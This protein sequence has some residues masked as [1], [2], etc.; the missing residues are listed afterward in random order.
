[1]SIFNYTALNEKGAEL[2]GR[3][4][5]DNQRL[6]VT[7][8]RGQSLF[9]VS[10]KQGKT[11]ASLGE[12]QDM[13]SYGS[14]AF[15]KKLLP[16]TAQDRVFFF[17]QLAMM[18][19]SGLTLLSALNHC[20][21]QTG[22]IKLSLAIGRMAKSIQGGNSFSYAIG[23][24]RKIFPIL[25]EKL[26][27]SSEVSGEMEQILEQ[28]ATHLTSRSEQKQNILTSL[29][30]PVIVL[31]VA[32]LVAAFLVIK[33]IPK[34]ALF[35]ARQDMDLPASTQMLIN[36]SNVVRANIPMIIGGGLVM[37]VTFILVYR[38]HKGKLFIDH[39]FLKIPVIG[40]LLTVGAMT[41]MSQTLSILLRSGVTL[42]ESLRVTSGI[43]ENRALHKCLNQA[44]DRILAGKDL[45]SS[46]IHSVVP[47]LVPQVVSV[48]EKSGTLVQVLDELSN[49][50]DKQL[51]A[52][53]KLLAGLIEPFMILIIGGMV[54]FVYLSFFQA[55]L[56]VST[57]R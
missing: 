9:V 6:A 10:I 49:F 25:A 57:G 2:R 53:T 30:Y 16:V 14:F 36:F 4:E 1:M 22:K 31:I 12:L 48:G 40:K 29:M 26:I 54:G 7:S 3:I 43:M 52:K 28:I 23:K 56:K 24:E 19:R 13:P 33:V 41:Q 5:A 39:L 45:A 38:T 34:F 47:P 44:S 55:V 51:Q 20:R 50:Y 17:Q 37:M 42:L 8:L 35:L 15:L 21:Q 11:N 32:L 27:E 46:L 18:M